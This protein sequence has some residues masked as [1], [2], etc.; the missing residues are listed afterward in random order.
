MA[1]RRFMA[2][3]DEKV[4]RVICALVGMAGSEGNGTLVVLADS[5]MP[6]LFRGNTQPNPLPQ[7]PEPR[8]FSSGVTRTEK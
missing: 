2:V 8:S 5:L 1:T 6:S 7:E 3:N 4:I